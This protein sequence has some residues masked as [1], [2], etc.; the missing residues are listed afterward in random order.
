MRGPA[1][2]AT[3]LGPRAWW[4]DPGKAKERARQARPVS[5]EQRWASRRAIARAP[6]C[7]YSRR[8]HS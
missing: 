7:G 2:K 8:A 6:D 5:A 3:R 1:P 4:H